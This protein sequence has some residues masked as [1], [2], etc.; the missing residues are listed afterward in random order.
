MTPT[1]AQ[2]LASL[3]HLGLI[4]AAVGLPVAVAWVLGPR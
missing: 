2:A 3:A 1:D 4:L